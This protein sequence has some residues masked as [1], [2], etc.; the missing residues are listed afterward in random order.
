[1]GLR[2]SFPSPFGMPKVFLRAFFFFIRS[3]PGGWIIKSMLLRPTS[4]SDVWVCMFLPIPE[5][6]A[7]TDH[8]VSYLRPTYGV[9][10][11]FV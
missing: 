11:H 1:M 2:R 7:S 6:T 4:F 10:P 3:A 9:N 5:H 8:L